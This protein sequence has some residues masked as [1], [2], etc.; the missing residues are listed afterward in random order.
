MGEI[1]YRPLIEDMVWSFSRVSAYGQCPRR[2]YLRYIRKCPE[3]EKF[4]ASYGTFMHELIEG[5]YSGAIAKEEMPAVFLREFQKRVRGRRPKNATLKKFIDG[6]VEYL[7]SFQPFPYKMIAV[8]QKVEFEIEGFKFLGF[9]DFLGYD[10]ADGELV[11]ID[12]KSRDLRQRSDREK[13]TV[14]DRELDEML[15][16]LY[17]YCVAVEQN[18]G[19]LPKAL[20]F[21]CFRTGTFIY[22]PF[23]QEAYEEAKQWV[24]SQ[25]RTI[26]DDS[27]FDPNPNPFACFW[28]C[29][30]SDH[31]EHAPET[32]HYRRR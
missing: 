20:C 8:E 1:N 11:L 24:V 16:Q 7:K 13:P 6:A 22:E 21:N 2:W 28:I 12:N 3:A 26:M 29:G 18:Y 15:R 19:R 14:K 17:V 25:I 4:F 23:N 31:C 5:Y 32:W 9:L 27:D 30:V 10:E